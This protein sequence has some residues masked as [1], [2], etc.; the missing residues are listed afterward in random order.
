[1]DKNIN[2]NDIE[3]L[4]IEI[5]SKAS[6][7][8]TIPCIYRPS[9]GDAHKFLDEMKGHIIKNKCQEKPLFLVCA[10]NINSLDYSRNTNVRHFFN[11]VF[12]NIIFPVI[13]RPTRVT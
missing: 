9:R 7:N 10:L 12:Q 13:N 8:V 3:C 1:M 2:N 4:N 11:F 6:K 5:A